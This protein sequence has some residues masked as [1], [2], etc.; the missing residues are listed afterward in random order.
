MNAAAPLATAL[1]LAF[2]ATSP[3]PAQ[4]ARSMLPLS[5][6]ATRRLAAADSLARAGHWSGMFRTLD[7]VTR[8]ADRMGDRVLAMRVRLSHGARLVLAGREREAEPL[9]RQALRRAIAMR[10]SVAEVHSDSW[11][12]AACQGVGRLTEARRVHERTLVLARLLYERSREAYALVGLAYCDLQAGDLTR[13]QERYSAA[14]DLMRAM[15]DGNGECTVLIGLGRVATGLGR[16][17]TART[18]FRSADSLALAAGLPG[19]RAHA[20]NNLGTLEHGEGDLVAAVAAYRG[21]IQLQRAAGNL[22]E[23]IT[24]AGNLAAVLARLGRTREALAMLDS[25][26]LECRQR[27]ARDLEAQVTV[28]LAFAQLRADQ[29]RTAIATLGPV[30]NPTAAVPLHVSANAVNVLA[31]ACVRLDSLEAGIL[32]VEDFLARHRTAIAPTSRIRLLVGLSQL[33][34]PAGRFREA[35]DRASLAA[36]LA[37]RHDYV[38]GLAVSTSLAG[39]ASL[40][41]NE[42]SRARRE[43]TAAN[44][45]WAGMPT[46][47]LVEGSMVASDGAERCAIALALVEMAAAPRA[48]A[49]TFERAFAALQTYRSRT[50]LRRIRGQTRVDEDAP[51]VS[52]RELRERVLEPGELLLDAYVGPDTSLLFAIR[53]EGVR[54]VHLP[55]YATLHRLVSPLHDLMSIPPRQSGVTEGDLTA[56]LEPVERLILGPLRSSIE[57]ARSMTL[58]TDVA[59]HDLPIEAMK[60]PDGQP[61]GLGTPVSRTPSAGILAELRRRPRPARGDL[62]IVVVDLPVARG[63]L[64]LPG[65]EQEI[66]RLARSY[67]GTVRIRAGGVAEIVAEFQRCDVLH[68]TGHADV[69][70]QRPWRSGLRLGGSGGRNHVLLTAADLSSVHSPAR[71]AVLSGCDAAEGQRI[72]GEGIE[73]LS[74]ALLIAGV[75]TIVSTHWPV[76]DAASALLMAGFYEGLA[77]GESVARALVSGR[78]KVASRRETYGPFYWAG[79]IVE[80]DGSRGV[81]VRTKGMPW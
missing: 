49:D 7:Q 46:S 3:L 32:A 21:A 70:I 56:A 18:R 76:D 65:V 27:G 28:D 33:L 64:Q 30:L 59:L 80:G 47:L 9:L 62:R 61:I 24:P 51:A 20:L 34:L 81:P 8:D 31:S 13:A 54:L 19:Q 69:D 5:P 23:A 71:L 26:A 25:L 29:P 40:R 16:F 17:A 55:G 58:S 15:R 53:Q 38:V 52:L 78:N 1:A 45:G 77:R 60:G 72:P 11:L 41:L 74:S 43:L 48:G 35:H 67:D 12:A 73:G 4:G 14:L 6:D 44:D 36:R 57:S 75:P 2:L 68:V 10:D 79:F 63:E 50:L 66:D 22:R 37:R 42:T 39:C